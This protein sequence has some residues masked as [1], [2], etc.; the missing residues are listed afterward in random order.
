MHKNILLIT[1]QRKINFRSRNKP[2]LNSFKGHAS[3]TGGHYTGTPKLRSQLALLA[4]EPVLHDIPAGGPACCLLKGSVS[5][6]LPA[7]ATRVPARA[8]CW[9]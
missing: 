3:E 9:G 6:A 5:I 1:T 8:C 4:P 7:A 2:E